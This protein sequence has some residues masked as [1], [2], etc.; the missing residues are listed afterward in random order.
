MVNYYYR[1][2]TANLTVHHYIEGTTTKVPSKYGGEVQDQT[3]SGPIGNPYITNPTDELTPRYEL[4]EIPEN[5]TGVYTEEEIIV[6]YFW[7]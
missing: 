3:T 4:V 6:N 5:S 7:N 2:K 1:L